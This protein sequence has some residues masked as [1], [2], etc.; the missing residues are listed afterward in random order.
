MKR[1]VIFF[2]ATALSLGGCSGKAKDPA[3]GANAP[4]DSKAAAG[5]AKPNP[6]NSDSAADGAADPATDKQPAAPKAD[7][8]AA[9]NPWAKDP[10]PGTGPTPSP[11][12][13]AKPAQ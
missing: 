3:A 4:K 7:A 6:W 8:K 5:P 11:T 10:P 2:A 9:S 1:A 13:K 12:N